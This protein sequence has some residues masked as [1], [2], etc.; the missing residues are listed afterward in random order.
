MATKFVRR[1]T[2]MQSRRVALVSLE[3]IVRGPT[4]DHRWSFIQYG[5]DA[6]GG[7]ELFDMEKDP[8]QYTNLAADPAHADRVAKF[9]EQMA[10]KLAE[11]RD[12]DL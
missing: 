8:K 12:N 4:A 6:K 9:R 1:Q 2:L 7:I 5:E 11:V 3:P 10:V